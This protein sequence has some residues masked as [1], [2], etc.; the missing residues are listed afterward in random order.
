[1]L[2]EATAVA[3]SHLGTRP[4]QS[5]IDV[6]PVAPPP[7]RLRDFGWRLGPAVAPRIDRHRK[8]W[9][10]DRPLQACLEPCPFNSHREPSSPPWSSTFANL[11]PFG[12]R[13]RVLRQASRGGTTP[14]RRGPFEQLAGVSGQNARC[15]LLGMPERSRYVRVAAVGE[16]RAHISLF[17]AQ[18]YAERFPAMLAA[19]L[20][21]AVALALAPRAGHAQAVTQGVR[22]DSQVATGLATTIA[23]QR[24]PQAIGVIGGTRLDAAPTPTLEEALQGQVAGVNVQ[25]NNGGAP[26]GGVQV[27]IRGIASINSDAEPLYVIDGVILNNQ[28]VDSGLNALTAAGPV[29]FAQDPEDNTPN[30]IADINPADIAHIEILKG[31]AASAIYGSKGAAGA[32]LI[33]TKRGTTRARSGI[34]P[35]ARART[36]PPT[37]C[38]SG[39]F[40]HTRAPTRGGTDDAELSGDVPTALYSGD[41][42]YQS[43][44]F[45]GGECRARGISAFAVRP[46]AATISCRLWTSTTNG[47]LEGTGYRKEGARVNLATSLSPAL[48]ASTTLYYQHSLSVRGS[49]ETTTTAS[50][51]TTCSRPHRPSST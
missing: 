9:N 13:A 36:C 8:L 45:G 31:P 29:P 24:A 16:F 17:H 34:S 37:H 20:A 47:V 23:A 3:A 40:P 25:Q 4:G 11:R 10:R 42:N 12:Q 44:L 32:I 46:A 43:Q 26:G 50:R 39:P 22:P 35:A 49:P 30:R 19:M 33:T 48:T 38:R 18:G 6:A 27:Q 7:H 14:T 1:M 28:T 21:G 2:S 51:R 5:R 41:H 15:A